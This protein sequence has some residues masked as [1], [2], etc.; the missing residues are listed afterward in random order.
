M[1]TWCQTEASISCSSP[2]PMVPMR[3]R[4][5]STLALPVFSVQAFMVSNQHLTCLYWSLSH[6]YSGVFLRASPGLLSISGVT[7]FQSEMESTF[8]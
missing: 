1:A 6:T 3:N 5:S 4:F 2:S 7:C 8:Y